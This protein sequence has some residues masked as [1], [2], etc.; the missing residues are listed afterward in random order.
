MLTAFKSNRLQHNSVLSIVFVTA[1]KTV[2]IGVGGGRAIDWLNPRSN[3]VLFY[4]LK[5]RHLFNKF[6]PVIGIHYLI[7]NTSTFDS[8]LSHINPD[9][10]LALPFTKINLD[11]VLTSTSR[12]L[13]AFSFLRI[14]YLTFVYISY[15]PHP[16]RFSS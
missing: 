14:S 9:N 7:N 16:P 11:T 10:T 3:Y 8:V 4:T 1:S 6:P 12:F 15:F 5:I 2:L 13:Q